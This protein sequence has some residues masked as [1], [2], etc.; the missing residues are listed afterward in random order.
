VAD[1]DYVRDEHGLVVYVRTGAGR[2]VPLT[3]EMQRKQQEEAARKAQDDKTVA[4]GGLPG[5]EYLPGYGWVQAVRS[6]SGQVLYYAD[7]QTGERIKQDRMAGPGAGNATN[8]KDAERIATERDHRQNGYEDDKGV[9]HPGIDQDGEGGSHGQWVWVDGKRATL[10]P[11]TNGNLTV[12]YA[13]GDKSTTIITPSAYGALDE[14]DPSASF[15]MTNFRLGDK[16]ENLGQN[17]IGGLLPNLLNAAATGGQNVMTI[18]GGLRWLVNLSTKDPEAYSAMIDKLVGAGYLTQAQALAAGGRWNSDVGNAFAKAAMELAVVNTT[19]EGSRTTLDQWLSSKA[20]AGAGSAAAGTTAA[21]EPMTRSYTD[22]ESVKAAAKAAAEQTLGRRLTPEEED[23]LVT[24]FRS[25][26]DGMFDAIDAQQGKGGGSYTQPQVTGQ[27][28]A[29]L[30]SGPR[31]QEQAN[32]ATAG[33]GDAL[34]DLF[35]KR[36]SLTP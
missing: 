5:Q 36:T 11:D 3:K 21:Y 35:S 24:H 29:Y 26:E 10:V 34:I 28:D 15:V 22:P 1:D 17:G 8:R 7:P 32:W 6:R 27:V 12:N 23:E 13:N 18:D 16:A 14:V 31:E 33:Y 25:L 19:P 9:K 20:A 2:M 4:A 30:D